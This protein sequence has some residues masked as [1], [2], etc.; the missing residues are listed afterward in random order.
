MTIDAQYNVGFSWARQYGLRVSKSFADNKLSVALSMEDAQ[1]TFGGKLQTQNTLIAAPGDLAGLYNNEANYSFNKSPDFVFKA[2]LDPGWGHYEIFGVVGTF[3]ARVFPCAGATAAA[4]CPINDSP[5]SGSLANN[6]AIT[7]GGI[8]GNARVPL[9]HHKLDAGIHFLGG[10][11]VGRYGNATL[12]DVTAHPDGTLVGLRSYQALGTLEFH[13]TPKLD[14][15]AYVGGE[16]DGRAA[17]VDANEK[18]VGYGS[19]LLRND[20]CSV[21][22]SPV[23]QNTPAGTNTVSGVVTPANCQGDIRN[24]IEGTLGFWYRFYQGPKGRVQ[25]GFQYSYAVRNTWRGTDSSGEGSFT[26]HAIDNMVFT[27]FRYY[28]P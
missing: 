24:I 20:G 7:A 9:F 2:A 19:P 12:A 25:Y 28:L 16:Y 6:Q 18:G 14:I 1:T 4:P 21:E 11:G 13:A 8:G 22:L 5:I 27:S 17:Y 10:S 15:Y 3:R 26:P 23:N